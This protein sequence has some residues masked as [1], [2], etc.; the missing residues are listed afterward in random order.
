MFWSGQTYSP[1]R[2]GDAL[3]AT[4][5]MEDL[6]WQEELPLDPGGWDLGETN[7]HVT[8]NDG[9]SSGPVNLMAHQLCDYLMDI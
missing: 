3:I 5:H 6:M 4:E 8:P 2:L 9:I 1:G 7:G